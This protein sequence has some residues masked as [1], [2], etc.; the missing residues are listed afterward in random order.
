MYAIPRTIPG[1]PPL[2]DLSFLPPQIQ[3]NVRFIRTSDNIRR[4][5]T[6]TDSRWYVQFVLR[7]DVAMEQGVVQKVNSLAK[8]MVTEGLIFEIG[9]GFHIL[10][11]KVGGVD[12]IIGVLAG[13]PV[14]GIQRG[15]RRCPSSVWRATFCLKAW[16]NVWS[17]PCVF[18]VN[19]SD[20]VG[21]TRNWPSQ[22]VCDLTAVQAK[23]QVASGKVMRIL[24][25][26][27]GRNDMTVIIEMFVNNEWMFEIGH[28]HRIMHV[29]A[30]VHEGSWGAQLMAVCKRAEVQE[31]SVQPV[32][33]HGED[34]RVW[35][36]I[37]H[38]RG[39]IADVRLK[40]A[41][42]QYSVRS[43]VELVDGSGWCEELVF[44][45]EVEKCGKDVVEEMN[46]AQWYVRFVE[47]DES[48]REK[49]QM[50]LSH[51]AGLL[52]ER[53]KVYAI[54]CDKP[55]GTQGLLYMWGLR[56]PPY[57]LSLLGV[58]APS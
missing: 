43:D 47:V 7:N 45:K 41:A 38:V 39:Q 1:L 16:G 17:V 40:C 11:G 32:L 48:G 46:G 31:E 6:A 50:Y 42:V 24:P 10:G 13:G 3:C 34:R 5:V 35:A 33:T 27:E 14:W 2:L 49:K 4:M 12:S 36:G 22:L 29:M 21:D 8:V 58:F 26:E 56:L 52:E 19:E 28:G 37:L 18:S 55:G 54:E 25:I 30:A 44:R 57:G 9:W 51:L 15:R 20:L 53:D 23:R